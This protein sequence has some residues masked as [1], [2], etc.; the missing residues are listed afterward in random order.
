MSKE[1]VERFFDAVKAD[2]AMMRGLAEADVDAVIRMAA[3]LDLEF[4]ESEL[5]TVLKEMLYAAKSLPRGWGWPLARRMGLV[6]S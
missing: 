5:K 1:N 2:H 3:G 4:T 6:H